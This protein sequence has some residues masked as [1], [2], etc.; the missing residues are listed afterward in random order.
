MQLGKKVP[1]K[2]AQDTHNPQG[3]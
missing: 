1:D 2:E 3:L